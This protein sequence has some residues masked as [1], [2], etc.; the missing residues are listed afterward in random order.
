MH[1]SQAISLLLLLITLPNGVIFVHAELVASSRIA[2]WARTYGGFSL[3]VFYSV[4]QTSD[5]GFVVAGETGSFGDDTTW[6]VRLDGFG[7]ILWQNVYGGTGCGGAAS[8]RQTSDGGFIVA[9]GGF[10]VIKLDTA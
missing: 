10:C 5:G 6:V 9:S 7:N 2:T 1:V 3:D 4:Q 8:V